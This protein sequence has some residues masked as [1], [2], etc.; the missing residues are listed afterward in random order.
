MDSYMDW[1][2]VTVFFRA[3]VDFEKYFV[4]NFVVLQARIAAYDYGKT[5]LPHVFLV[6]DY[7][8]DFVSMDKDLPLVA[9]HMDVVDMVVNRTAHWGYH[10]S[11]GLEY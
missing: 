11:I 5:G 9:G 2:F 1:L 4:H 3:L 10:G 6:H 8:L 7:S